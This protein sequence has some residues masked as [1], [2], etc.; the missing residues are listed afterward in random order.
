M[1]GAGI[2][3]RLLRGAFQEPR[4]DGSPLA[5][6]RILIHT[7]QG[8]GDILQFIRY[9]PLVKARGGY[10]IFECQKKL[11]PLLR[12]FGGIDQLALRRKP[13]PLFEVEIPLPACRSC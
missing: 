5:G 9:V 10:V 8:L 6:R 1:S 12:S 13:W 7:E 11:F 2:A 4:W 3:I